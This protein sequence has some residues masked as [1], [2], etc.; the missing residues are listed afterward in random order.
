[1]EACLGWL[2]NTVP[3][4]C[5]AEM[6]CFHVGFSMSSSLR[7]NVGCEIAQKSFKQQFPKSP[8]TTTRIHFV[9]LSTRWCH[10]K[11]V[12]SRVVIVCARITT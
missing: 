7:E 4:I 9:P 1:M 3:S 6:T 10:F 2:A 8:L 11:S 5:I 12:V